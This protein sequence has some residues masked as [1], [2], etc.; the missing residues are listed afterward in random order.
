MNK[1]IK[2][3]GNLRHYMCW[4][5]WL[6]IPLV[7]LN[8]PLYW[9]SRE[10]GIIVSMFLV[11]Y[12]IAVIAAYRKSKPALLR[13]MINFATQYGTVQKKLIN[14]FE[15]PYAL[16]DYGGKILWV[17]EAFTEMTGKDKDYHSRLRPCFRS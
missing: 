9:V 1:N 2:L 14:E 16:L 17:N 12:L 3:K 5:L 7:A 13:E 6:A 11:V 10:S 8:L 15:I 4:P